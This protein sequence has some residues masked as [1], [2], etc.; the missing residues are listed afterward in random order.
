VATHQQGVIKLVAQAAEF[1]AI[2][3]VFSEY[4]VRATAIL[5]Q[6]RKIHAE[7]AITLQSAKQLTNRGI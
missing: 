4:P 7:S 6:V 5:S 3:V 1:V 2:C